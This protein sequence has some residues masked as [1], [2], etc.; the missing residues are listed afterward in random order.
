MGSVPGWPQS[1]PKVTLARFTPL[2]TF[3]HHER[4]SWA[5]SAGRAMHRTTKSTIDRLME[6]NPNDI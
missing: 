2:D 3:A 1:A 6:S 5:F 4:T